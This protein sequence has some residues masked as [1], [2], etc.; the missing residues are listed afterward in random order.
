MTQLTALLEPGDQVQ[1]IE[2]DP[3]LGRLDADFDPRVLTDVEAD[4]IIEE[5]EQHLLVESAPR[6][7]FNSINNIVDNIVAEVVGDVANKKGNRKLGK[8]IAGLAVTV[9]SFV[10]LGAG[11]K[12]YANHPCLDGEYDVTGVDYGPNGQLIEYCADDPVVVT[13]VPTV[14]TT[15]PPPPTPAPTT[16]NT[17]APTEAT[18]STVEGTTTTGVTVT[19]AVTDTDGSQNGDTTIAKGGSSG[20]NGPQGADKNQGNGSGGGGV[21]E[22]KKI[23]NDGNGGQM[24]VFKEGFIQRNALA[25]AL[26]TMVSFVGGAIALV[27]RRGE[28]IYPN[29][30]VVIPEVPVVKPGGDIVVIPKPTTEPWDIGSRGGNIPP[31]AHARTGTNFDPNKR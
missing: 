1:P 4:S 25:L 23:I 20:N 9:G 17:P 22:I 16:P 3:G 2:L 31:I 14:H 12:V 28:N 19:E 5:M 13:T 8:W 11:D 26:T 6:V 30:V 10:G 21:G 18:T 15:L 29:S 27:R 7:D 24:V